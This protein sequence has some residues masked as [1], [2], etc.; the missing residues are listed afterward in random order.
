MREVWRTVSNEQQDSGRGFGAGRR[1]LSK[2][3]RPLPLFVLVFKGCALPGLYSR[4]PE[5]GTTRRTVGRMVSAEDILSVADGGTKGRVAWMADPPRS[6]GVSLLAPRY[7][8]FWDHCARNRIYVARGEQ[9]GDPTLIN[10]L[11]RH[12]K[13]AVIGWRGQS[14]HV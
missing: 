14:T 1:G 3:P 10:R 4:R 6:N 7:L 5:V 13:E 11:T 9:S 2:A 12:D 8:Y